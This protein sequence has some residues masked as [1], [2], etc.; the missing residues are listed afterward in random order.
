MGLRAAVVTRLAREDWG[1]VEEL[2]RQGVT[3][4]ARET[5]VSS[6]LRLIYSTENLDQRTLELTSV[7]GPFTLDQIEGINSRVWA[8]TASSAR[9][10]V[11][12]ELIQALAAREVMLGL[13]VQGFVRVLRDG[14]LGYDDWPGKESVLPYV[15]V[16]K[17]DAMEA[18]IL[19][20]ERDPFAAAR[21][22]AK[23][24]PREILLT[25]NGGELVYHDG[26]FD[27]APFVPQAVRGRSGRGDTCHG[28]YLSRRLTAPPADAVIWAAA[29][30][31]LKLEREGAFDRDLAEVE[32]LYRQL[33][34]AAQ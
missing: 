34:R 4:F 2:Q 27:Q 9:G 23:F 7:A 28:A 13:D 3:M 32:A 33:R 25:H 6:Q 26:V 1:A 8:I 30:T 19:T 16:L 18:E 11:P 17:T 21:G 5:P 14:R 20:G 22:L 24:G 31:S 29:V 12:P 10:E 15:T